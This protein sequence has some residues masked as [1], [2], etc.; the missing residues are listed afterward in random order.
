MQIVESGLENK[1]AVMVLQTPHLSFFQT[2]SGSSSPSIQLFARAADPIP[3]DET[4]CPS[5]KAACETTF[6]NCSS[7]G[8]CTQQRDPRGGSGKCWTCLCNIN[9]WT[10]DNG[11]PVEGF[12]SPVHWTGNMCQFQ[13]IST[14]FQIVF[15]VSLALI[16]LLT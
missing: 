15:W 2:S 10:D 5:S 13:D 6:G 7:H 8:T 16:L 4:A 9:V 14:S 3:K 12:S 1:K 11:K